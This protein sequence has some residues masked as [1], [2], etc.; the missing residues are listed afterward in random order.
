MPTVVGCKTAIYI[1]HSGKQSR[2]VQMTPSLGGERRLKF[3][4]VKY[5]PPVSD[6]ETIAGWPLHPSRKVGRLIEL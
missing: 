1:S 5:F 4:K 3:N 2:D 6:K